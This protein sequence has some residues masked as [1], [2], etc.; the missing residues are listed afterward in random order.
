MSL[1]VALVVI[2]GGIGAFAYFHNQEEE[3]CCPLPPDDQL[4]SDGVFA[5][6]EFGDPDVNWEPTRTW[7]GVTP[8]MSNAEVHTVPGDRIWDSEL[9]T[10][11]LDNP[12]I[13]YDPAAMEETADQ[14]LWQFAHDSFRPVA[15]VEIEDTTSEYYD[16]HGQ[17]GVLV[18]TTFTWEPVNGTADTYTEV[19]VLV[20]DMGDDEAWLG[21]TATREQHAEYYDA[22]VEYLLDVELS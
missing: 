8:G 11:Q 7:E 19:A 14:L 20:I 10:G 1:S 13:E 5:E 21:F 6:A 2:L 15:P 18:E 3:L 9:M 22:T 4:T 12:L 17:V 16:I